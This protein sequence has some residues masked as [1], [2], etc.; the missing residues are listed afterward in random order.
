MNKLLVVGIS[1]QQIAETPDTLITYA[2][3]SCV[4][5]CIYDIVKQVG[6]LSHILL[7]KAFGERSEKNIYKFADTAIPALVTAMEQKGCLRIHLTAKI[8]G[9]ATM[10]SS[11]SGVSIGKQNVD[12]VK[13]Q[14]Q[15]LRIPIVA[16]DTGA[17]YGRTV[18]FCTENGEVTVKTARKGDKRL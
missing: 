8:A 16:E 4:G 10:F 11:F 12:M 3:G 18:Q 5:I 15:K 2:L 9:G 7:P 17:D 6:G 14:L 1:D 13:A